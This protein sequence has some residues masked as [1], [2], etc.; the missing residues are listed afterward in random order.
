MK[1]YL[2][3]HGGG[4]ASMPHRTGIGTCVCRNLLIRIC[5]GKIAIRLYDKVFEAVCTEQLSYG[6]DC[7]YQDANIDLAPEVVRVNERRVEWICAC[8]LHVTTCK[9]D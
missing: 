4:S 6:T 1:D 5:F 2:G 9:R 7:V 8:E 3:R